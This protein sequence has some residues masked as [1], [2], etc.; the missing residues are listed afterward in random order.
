M[1]KNIT[2]F[3][4]KINTMDQLFNCMFT[5]RPSYVVNSGLSWRAKQGAHDGGVFFTQVPGLLCGFYSKITIPER[6]LIGSTLGHFARRAAH[7]TDVGKC[8]T[9]VAM[10]R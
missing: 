3:F 8:F 2:F 9:Q 6:N 10:Y 7:R 5:R 1:Y 4:L